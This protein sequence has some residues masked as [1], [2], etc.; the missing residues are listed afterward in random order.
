LGQVACGRSV[1]DDTVGVATGTPTN[2]YF[3][4]ICFL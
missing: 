1:L 4:W 2:G 3:R